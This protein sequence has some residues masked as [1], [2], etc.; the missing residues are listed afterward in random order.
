MTAGVA[1]LPTNLGANPRLSRWLR[2]DAQGFVEVSP[3]KIEIGQGIV[4]ALAQIAADELDIDISRVRINGSAS[5]RFVRNGRFPEVL[6]SVPTMR[7]SVGSSPMR[8]LSL[9]VA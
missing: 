5:I 6:R 8:T 9:S 1:S 4:T 3:G 7:L 2:F